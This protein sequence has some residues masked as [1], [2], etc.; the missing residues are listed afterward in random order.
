MSRSKRVTVRLSDDE[1]SRLQALSSA[2]RMPISTY[3]RENALE[4]NNQVL[5]NKFLT[6]LRVELDRARMEVGL[7]KAPA[8]QRAID[9]LEGTLH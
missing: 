1:W 7:L 4:G 9:L 6:E 8:L 2:A 3:L 5:R